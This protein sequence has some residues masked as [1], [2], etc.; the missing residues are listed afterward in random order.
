[1]TNLVNDE[2]NSYK[3][4]KLLASGAEALLFSDIKSQLK[5]TY[6]SSEK[7]VVNGSKLLHNLADTWQLFSHG[8]THVTNFKFMLKFLEAKSPQF[9]EYESASVLIGSDS[10]SFREYYAEKAQV[11]NDRISAV[12]EDEPQD[13]RSPALQNYYKVSLD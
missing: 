13:F 3:G 1:M 8:N 7:S 9:A 11:T 10:K 4:K 6:T 5:Q 12:M 2:S